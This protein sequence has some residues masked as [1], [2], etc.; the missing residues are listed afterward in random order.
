MRTLFGWRVMPWAAVTA[1]RTIPFERSSRKLVLVQ[2]GGGRGISWLHLWSACLGAGFKPGIL[3]TLAIRD[4]EPLLGRLRQEVALAAPQAVFDE[5]FFSLPARLVFE[6]AP[7]LDGLACWSRD[8]DWTW[9]TWP[10]RPG[11]WLPSR[12]G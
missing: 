2:G 6:P 8:E 11:S 12:P 1:V 10:N 5:Q 4:F 3:F 7:T 9:L